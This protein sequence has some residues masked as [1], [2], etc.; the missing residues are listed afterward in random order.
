LKKS[1]AKLR[2][3]SVS[4]EVDLRGMTG[5]EAVTVMERYLDGAKR[6]NLTSVRVIHGKGTGALRIAVQ[7]SLKRNP[8]VKSFR[9]GHYGEGETGVTVVEFDS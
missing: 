3:L 8:I 4:P 6:A 2:T 1:E 7:N 9:L 5:D